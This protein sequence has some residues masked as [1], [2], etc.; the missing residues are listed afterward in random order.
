M[1]SGIGRSKEDTKKM[2]QENIE[3]LLLTAN[4]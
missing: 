4:N 2:F 1:T 3:K